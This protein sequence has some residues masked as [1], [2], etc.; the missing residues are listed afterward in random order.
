MSK[1]NRKPPAAFSLMTVIILVIVGVFSFSA[2]ITISTFAPD[3]SG[4]Q[5]SGGHA[6]SHSAI[7][8]A[9][10]V[11]L[12]RAQGRVVTANRTEGGSSA[13]ARSF[14]ILTP[15]RAIEETAFHRVV[16]WRTLIVLPKHWGMP[17]LTRAGWIGLN[18]TFS[19]EAV[20]GVLAEVIAPIEV[21]QAKDT[22]APTL[23]FESRTGLDI[24]RAPL[25][26]GPITGLQTIAGEDLEPILRTQDGKI[27]LARVYANVSSGSFD[28]DEP[29]D[30]YVLSDPD[31]LNTQGIAD[32]KT[33]AAGLR[34]IEA[35]NGTD[36]IVFDV[37][38]NGLAR[39]RDILKVALQPPFLGATLSLVIAACLL[40]WRAVAHVTPVIAEGRAIALGKRALAENSAAL[41]RLAGREH[42][43][44]G[45]YA[46]LI[47]ANTAEQLGLTGDSE[48]HAIALDR[49]S[50]STGAS[51][52]YSD[53]AAEAAAARDPAELLAAARKLHA[54]N[55][56]VLRATR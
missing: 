43:M 8:Y 17:S 26:A 53:L 1:G 29:Q 54:W 52:R 47:A 19:P 11:K 18:G 46:S 28:D 32:F 44:G 30:F 22:S 39:S 4:D 10:I 35:L 3:L 34:I 24:D 36:P 42:R 16:G 45:R 55:E 25:A 33:A 14:N 5:D 21:E 6:L 15:E 31:F 48:D 40:G 7:G 27:V 37:T 20:E 23:T 12:M 9:G 51:A 56:E 50:A 38:L 41:I 2:F 49:I 13:V